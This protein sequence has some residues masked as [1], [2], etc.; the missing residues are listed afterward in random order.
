MMKGGNLPSSAVHANITM[1]R[2]FLW[3]VVHAGTFFSYEIESIVVQHVKTEGCLV[4]ITNM[5]EIVTT[6]FLYFDHI[7]LEIY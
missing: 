3:L 7:P 5:S 1:K 4:G 6:F 2:A